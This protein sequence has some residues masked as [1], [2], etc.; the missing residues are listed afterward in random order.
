MSGDKASWVEGEVDRKGKSAMQLALGALSKGPKTRAEIERL[1]ARRGVAGD[2]ASEC[3]E[4]LGKSRLVD[5]ALFARLWVES[6]H[7]SRNLSR[8][9]MR[10]E[11]E[12]RGVC[13]EFIG[14]ALALVGDED[15]RDAARRVAARGLKRNRGADPV[16]ARRRV[17][18]M[19]MRRG[20]QAETVW[21]VLDECWSDAGGGERSDDTG[22]WSG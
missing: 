1:L 11:L 2:E 4:R 8:E 7:R 17:A 18:G 19:L 15:E 20:Y 13:E 16:V 10:D 12:A 5:D 3:V 21:S 6:R 14:Q 9:R 22:E